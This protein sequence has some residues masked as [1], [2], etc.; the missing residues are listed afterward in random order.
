[1]ASLTDFGFTEKEM[2]E[3]NSDSDRLTKS[4]I[5]P[6]CSLS[7]EDVRQAIREADKERKRCQDKEERQRLAKEEEEREQQ[8]IQEEKRK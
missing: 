3:W 6:D 8:R 7:A 4:I 2:K 5:G 1:M